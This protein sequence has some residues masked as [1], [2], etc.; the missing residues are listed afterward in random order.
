MSTVRGA[1]RGG[2]LSR[3]SLLGWQLFWPLWA[4]EP[5]KLGSSNDPMLA[6]HAPDTE[7]AAPAALRPTEVALRAHIDSIVRGQPN[8]DA[9]GPEVANAVRTQQPLFEKVARLG[10]VRSIEYRGTAAKAGV[11]RYDVTSAH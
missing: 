7:A 4:C 11:D 3:A 5:G 2:V 6:A 10:A 9:M 8:F 1:L